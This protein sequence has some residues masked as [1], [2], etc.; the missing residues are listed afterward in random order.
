MLGL[1][2]AMTAQQLSQFGDPAQIQRAIEQGDTK[3]LS[4]VEKVARQIQ[5]EK[6]DLFNKVQAMYSMFMGRR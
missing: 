6:P 5:Q 1:T 3:A 4:F 2:P